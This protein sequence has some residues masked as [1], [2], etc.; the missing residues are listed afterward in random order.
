MHTNKTQTPKKRA[1]N[2]AEQLAKQQ[3]L[4][5]GLEFCLSNFQCKTGEI[6]LIMK[7]GDCLVFVEVRYRSHSELGSPLE[8]VTIS[9]QKKLIRTANYFLQQQFRNNWPPCRFD[10]VG[11]TG[12]LDNKPKIEWIENAFC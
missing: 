7:Q 6:D 5:K 4:D 12:D 3:L 1:G 8:T 10:V 9:K 11:I 2:Q